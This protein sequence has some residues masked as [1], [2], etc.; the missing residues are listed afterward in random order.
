MGVAAT[1]YHWRAQMVTVVLSVLYFVPGSGSGSGS[2][3][4]EASSVDK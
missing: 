4:D 3:V 2:A 1:H